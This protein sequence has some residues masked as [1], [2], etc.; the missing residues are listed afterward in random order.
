MRSERPLTYATRCPV[1]SG[2]GS[3]TGPSVGTSCTCAGGEVDREEP[4]RE[5]E[6]RHRRLGVGGVGD[7]AAGLLADALAASA[8]LRGQIV[9]GVL[10]EIG[11]VD[12][13]DFLVL[14][15]VVHPQPVRGVVAGARA[16]EHDPLAV[17]ARP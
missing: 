3:N 16:Q 7:D 17:A 11:G 2:R 9:V 4:A 15:D 13:V 8:L 12:H 1:G 14:V 6:R 5:R 10:E